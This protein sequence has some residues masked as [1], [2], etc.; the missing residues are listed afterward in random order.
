MSI[1][2]IVEDTY[3]MELIDAD[4]KYEIIDGLKT[5]EATNKVAFIAMST[6]IS[7]LYELYN[8]KQSGGTS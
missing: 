8:Y 2:E 4:H 5:L 6:Y 1:Y 7:K 3:K